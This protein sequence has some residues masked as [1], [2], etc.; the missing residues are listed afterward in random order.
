[1][2]KAVNDASVVCCFMTP[3][4]ENSPNCELELE[5]AQKLRKR[6]IPCMVSNRKAWKPDPSKWLDFITGSILAIDFSDSS[7]ENIRT[8]ASEL[9]DRIKNQSSAPKQNPNKLIEL[10]KR[11]YLEKNQIKRIVNEGKSLSIEQ[12][13]VNLAMVDTREQQG[14]E[15]KLGQKDEENKPEQQEQ[16]DYR[17]EQHNHKIL[18]TFEEIYGTKTS[19]DVDKIFEKCKELTKKVLVL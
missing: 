19:I 4:Y 2:A 14:K 10:I 17:R 6:I 13:Y 1:M 16:E 8:K 15:K 7:E 5:H 9:I 18:D 3:E 12:S 11:Q